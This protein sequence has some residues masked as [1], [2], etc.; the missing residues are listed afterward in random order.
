MGPFFIFGGVFARALGKLF[1]FS[2]ITIWP[3][4]IV[5]TS[6]EDTSERLINH[7][8]IHFEQAKELLVIGFYLLYLY[9]YAKGLIITRSHK[10]AYYG[11]KFEKEAYANDGDAG[12]LYRR[13]PHAYKEY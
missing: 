5:T 2:G 7:E 4:I 10:E 12:Y 11:I 1:G 3:F 6:Q 9:Y 13:S 8:L